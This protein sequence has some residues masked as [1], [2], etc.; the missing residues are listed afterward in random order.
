[1]K[2]GQKTLDIAYCRRLAVT[3]GVL[4]IFGTV[5]AAVWFGATIGLNALASRMITVWGVTSA[6]LSRAPG[7]LKLLYPNLNA[8]IGILVSIILG[9]LTAVGLRLILKE[10]REA[11]A[12]KHAIFAPIALVAG[13][14]MALIPIGILLAADSIRFALPLSEPYLSNALPFAII[15]VLCVS[16]AWVLFFRG[17]FRYARPRIGLLAA[18]IMV[19]ALKVGVSAAMGARGIMLLNAALFGVLL[20]L[21]TEAGFGLTASALFRFGFT[22][23]DLCI[24]GASGNR[25]VT[26]SVY[27]AYMVSERWLSGG[28]AG[29]MNGVLV[30]VLF[31]ALI[32]ALLIFRRR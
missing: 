2:K 32:S 10:K 24:F 6:N 22:L 20:C 8:A 30:T 31:A 25:F 14:L 12:K 15:Q 13:V 9:F 29:L 4:L 5:Y 23:T 19:A 21:L 7:W 16:F 26:Q 11:D 1:M 28:S 18:V 3:G 27:D 17:L